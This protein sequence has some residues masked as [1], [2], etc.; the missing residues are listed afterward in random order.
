MITMGE[1]NRWPN[2]LIVGTARAGTT[3]L[4]EYL[5]NHPDIFMP[6]QKEPCYFT[7]FDNEPQFKESRHRYT[8]ET[9]DYLELFKGHTEKIAGESSTPYLYFHQ[10]T[11]AN[12]KNLV[13]NYGEIKILIILRDPAERAYSQYMHNRRDLREPLSFEEAIEQ[14]SLRKKENWHFDFFYTDKGFYF[15]Q[16][17]D[18]LE[19]FKN[20]KI[21][22][23]D[24]LEK[25]P[26]KLLTD[27]Y[28]FLNVEPLEKKE[29]IRRNQSGE[30]KVKWFKQIITTRKNPILNFF[31]KLLSRETKKRLRNW[32]KDKLLRYNLK[33]TEMEPQVRK[34][35]IELYR[36][37][38]LK[39]QKIVD[40]DLSDWLRA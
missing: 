13:A 30:M 20:V 35:L 40:K 10:K 3:S 1:Q 38:I 17:K 14:E 7:F 28:H 18:Y 22:F 26:D 9:E 33:K 34:K 15:G 6:L 37:D 16:V 32:T 27:I 29:M 25:N 23:Y 24:A 21:V 31:R 12:I 5:G 19:N 36:E 8:T 11:I 2:F 39:L 4:H